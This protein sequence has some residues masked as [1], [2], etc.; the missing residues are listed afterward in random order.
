MALQ[1]VLTTLSLTVI[2]PSAVITLRDPGQEGVGEGVR[3]VEMYL[4]RK[5]QDY[6]EVLM[7]WVCANHSHTAG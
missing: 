2:H 1:A 4:H 5:F 7:V 3:Q 6:T